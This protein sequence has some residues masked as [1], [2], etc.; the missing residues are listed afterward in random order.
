[1]SLFGKRESTLEMLVDGKFVCTEC[2]KMLHLANYTPL[3]A[4]QC[5]HCH[6]VNFIPMKIG[7]FFRRLVRGDGSSRIL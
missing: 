7:D 6:K 2:N 1:M 3:V 5:A 4:G